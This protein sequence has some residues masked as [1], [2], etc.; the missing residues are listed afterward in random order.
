MG[1]FIGSCQI[2]CFEDCIG[3]LGLMTLRF[4]RKGF[5][6][7]SQKYIML[8]AYDCDRRGSGSE[9]SKFAWCHEGVQG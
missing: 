4:E 6:F 3:L 2:C 8:K 9:K 1:D 7:L 5:S